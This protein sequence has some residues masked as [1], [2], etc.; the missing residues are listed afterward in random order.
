MVFCVRS[1]CDGERL[2]F[3]MANICFQAICTDTMAMGCADCAITF[4]MFILS[5]LPSWKSKFYMTFHNNL[6]KLMI[7]KSG[8]ET[9][10]SE[11]ISKL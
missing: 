4:P 2:S 10:V 6:F 9:A 7:F 5:S 8:L 11:E 1:Q 3:S